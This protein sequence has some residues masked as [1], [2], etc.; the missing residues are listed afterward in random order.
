M[1]E[2]HVQRL[3]SLQKHYNSDFL[4]S[5]S[6]GLFCLKLW[7]LEVVEFSWTRSSHFN[8]NPR[9]QEFSVSLKDLL[10]IYS[11]IYS[12]FTMDQLKFAWLLTDNRQWTC[13]CLLN[14]TEI[15]LT[16]P[17]C[18]SEPDI[19]LLLLVWMMH[20]CI[21]FQ[22]KSNPSSKYNNSLWHNIPFLLMSLEVSQISSF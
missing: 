16:W 22:R 6:N 5:L 19:T 9:D 13:F 8:R 12:D 18:K 15:S 17:N 10:T 7:T 20:Q 1:C 3:S 14:F 4:V 2:G 11:Q 21:L